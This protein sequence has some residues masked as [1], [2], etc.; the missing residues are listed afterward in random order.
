M[1]QQSKLRRS[2]GKRSSSFSCSYMTCSLVACLSTNAG[3]LTYSERF[4]ATEIYSHDSY[5]VLLN[6]FDASFCL[7]TVCSVVC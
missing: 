2:S 6:L 3:S 7:S 4:L 1:E 5:E